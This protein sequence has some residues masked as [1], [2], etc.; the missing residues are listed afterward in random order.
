MKFSAVK[1]ARKIGWLRIFI[2][3]VIT[4]V[5]VAVA[6]IRYWYHNGLNAIDEDSNVYQK[7]VV[8]T[9]A[10]V[11]EIGD[12]LESAG[13]IQNSTAFSW[14]VKGDQVG[15]SLQAGTYNLSP[16]MSVPIIVSLMAEGRID[17]SLVTILPGQRLDEIR[18]ELL[19]YHWSEQALDKA[20]DD[21][22]D[23]PLLKDLPN[24]ASL[25]GYIYPDS[26]EIDN[27]TTPKQLV[28]RTLDNFYQKIEERDLLNKLK[29]Q[30]LN[31]H[32][33]ITLASIVEKEA[34]N[35]EDK[36]QIAQVFLKR[37][38]ENMVLGSDV[39]FFYAAAIENVT[40]A[41]DIDSPY[42]TRLHKG[43]PPGPIANMTISSLEAVAEPAKGD[44]LYFVAGDDG[45][46][47][48]SKTLAEHNANVAKY[49]VELCELP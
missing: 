46:T 6:G 34:G 3:I 27:N 47:Y 5:I 8:E 23:H 13:I 30:G 19:G 32:Q 43:L 2:P 24:G 40:P 15:V 31:L 4:L 44:Y 21:R 36:P 42:N 10:S 7:F 18:P 45:H 39:T 48:F 20:L 29:L 11:S 33:A 37:L 17:A 35:E 16:S 12:K 49:C 9:G 22:Y 38:R 25:E 1:K 41:V 26:Y 14:Y 28:T